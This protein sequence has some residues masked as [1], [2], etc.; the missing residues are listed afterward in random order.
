MPTDT[1]WQNALVFTVTEET[2]ITAPELKRER[3]PL[4]LSQM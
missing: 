1:V 3:Q 4:L 2:V